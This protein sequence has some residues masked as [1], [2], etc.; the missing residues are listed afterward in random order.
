MTTPVL[1]KITCKWVPNAVRMWIRKHH[2][3]EE[4]KI[5]ANFRPLIISST[6]SNS[7]EEEPTEPESY[8]QPLLWYSAIMIL[9]L[10]ILFYYFYIVSVSLINLMNFSH[11]KSLPSVT[12]SNWSKNLIFSF[13]TF[14]TSSKQRKNVK[15]HSGRLTLSS[16]SLQSRLK[17]ICHQQQKTY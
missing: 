9:S 17:T 16:A 10:L 4:T 5:D 1:F 15:S 7:V 11:A 2:N 12:H 3:A 13:R 6:S 8:C 14:S